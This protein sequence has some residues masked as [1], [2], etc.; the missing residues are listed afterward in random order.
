MQQRAT[1]VRFASV[2]HRRAGVRYAARSA[3]M[4]PVRSV[5][6]T[7][8]AHASHLCTNVVMHVPAQGDTPCND[9]SQAHV[10]IAMQPRLRRRPHQTCDV[11]QIVLCNECAA[12][13]S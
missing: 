4:A 13:A 10:C 2:P 1:A 12:T 9:R 11:S 8:H 6:H 7:P 5:V 3:A